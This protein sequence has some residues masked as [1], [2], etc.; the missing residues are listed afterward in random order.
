M[1][2]TVALTPSISSISIAA[3]QTPPLI[4][5]YQDYS[6]K[7]HF[8]SVLELLQATLLQLLNFKESWRLLLL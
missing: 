4:L 8:C 3:V 2:P 5:K 7:K 6:Y 1:T